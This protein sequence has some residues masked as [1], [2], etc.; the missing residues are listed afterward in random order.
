MPTAAEA[1]RHWLVL[2]RFR[3][4]RGGEYWAGRLGIHISAVGLA[5][6]PRDVLR[7]ETRISLLTAFA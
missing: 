1:L 5:W 3:F 6:V 2:A 4:D 7:S